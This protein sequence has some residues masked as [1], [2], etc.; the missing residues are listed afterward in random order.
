MLCGAWKS[1]TVGQIASDYYFVFANR[2]TVWSSKFRTTTNSD[3]AA[4]TTTT[5][6]NNNYN[7]N[8]N[9]KLLKI[10]QE[11][12]EQH[13]WKVSMKEMQR[14]AILGTELILPKV[15]I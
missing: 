9:W 13:S 12:P 2:P 5:N 4:T 3:A 11:I 14:T 15:L 6:N 1:N 10:I 8:V 7:N